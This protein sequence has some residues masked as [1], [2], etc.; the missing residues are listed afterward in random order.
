MLL[1]HNKIMCNN[2]SFYPI[3]QPQ[4]LVQL[5]HLVVNPTDRS[6]GI[7]VSKQA[8]SVSLTLQKE[9]HHNQKYHLGL[10]SSSLSVNS[11]YWYQSAPAL[12]TGNGLRTNTSTGLGTQTAKCSSLEVSSKFILVLTDLRIGSTVIHPRPEIATSPAGLSN[13]STRKLYI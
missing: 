1:C 8:L 9:N 12:P 13:Q 3:H 4:N 7:Q 6:E 2:R 11:S 5:S 10:S